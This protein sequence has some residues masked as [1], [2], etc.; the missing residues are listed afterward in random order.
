MPVLIGEECP[1]LAVAQTRLVKAHVRPDV[2]GV[3]VNPTAE[4]SLAPLGV[5]AQLIA[6]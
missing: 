6:V 2:D 4:F 5:A 3:E 1:Y